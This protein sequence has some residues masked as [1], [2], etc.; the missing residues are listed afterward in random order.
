MKRL[1][2]ISVFVEGPSVGP[3]LK[4]HKLS[5]LEMHPARKVEMHP[6]RG[7]TL[8]EMA[9]PADALEPDPEADA[10]IAGFFARMIRPRS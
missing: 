10:R 1:L 6:R 9:S 8:C 5:P 4:S 7:H 3:R 2:K